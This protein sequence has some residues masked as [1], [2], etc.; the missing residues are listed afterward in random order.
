[1]C[2]ERHPTR[3]HAGLPHQPRRILGHIMAGPDRFDKTDLR[4]KKTEKRQASAQ[5]TRREK[6]KQHLHFSKTRVWF[7]SNEEAKGLGCS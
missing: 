5:R 4:Q 7:S 6:G 2:S 3:F 1:M